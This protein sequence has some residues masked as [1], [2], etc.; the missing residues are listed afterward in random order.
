MKKIVLFLVLILSA[1]Q[2]KADNTVYLPCKKIVKPVEKITITDNTYDSYSGYDFTGKGKP[3]YYD[4]MYSMYF[5]DY[6]YYSRLNN[7]P[8]FYMPAIRHKNGRR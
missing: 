6:P 3:C 5:A 2:V 4:P 1:L 7:Y 8:A